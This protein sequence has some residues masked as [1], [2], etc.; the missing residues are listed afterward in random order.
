MANT[1]GYELRFEEGCWEVGDGW[2]EE[3]GREQ[4][5]AGGEQE[6]WLKG[7]RGSTREGFDT[8][9]VTFF[10][11][12]LGA[13]SF[14]SCLDGREG[15]GGDRTFLSLGIMDCVFLSLTLSLSSVFG[16]LGMR[17]TAAFIPV[18]RKLSF[19]YCCRRVT[20]VPPLFLL[21]FRLLAVEWRT[22]VFTYSVVDLGRWRPVDG[23]P[24]TR[25]T[26][27]QKSRNVQ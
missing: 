17:G 2:E 20:A 22:F 23:D 5:L 10:F 24:G 3:I 16:E 13:V 4:G 26:S 14:L 12:A 8:M 7:R 15:L 21:P 1:R 27:W 25:G 9:V 6:C 18:P 11:F 19:V